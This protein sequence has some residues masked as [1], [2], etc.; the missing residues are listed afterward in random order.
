MSEHF[1][2]GRHLPPLVWVLGLRLGNRL[3]WADAH[4][5]SFRRGCLRKGD[6]RGLVLQSFTYI[7]SKHRNLGAPDPD[8]Q[9]EILGT[10]LTRA[11]SDPPCPVHCRF[12]WPAIAQSRV[13]RRVGRARTSMI[14]RA[15]DKR[16]IYVHNMIL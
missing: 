9:T 2:P 7:R 3:N 16:L 1:H 12:I 15:I 11:T 6:V 10:P 14:D 8:W 4:N 13:I 5:G